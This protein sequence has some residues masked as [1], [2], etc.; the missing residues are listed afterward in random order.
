V[1]PVEAV[2]LKD[3]REY[4]LPLAVIEYPEIAPLELLL[5]VALA[6]YT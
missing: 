1:V 6:T 5:T 3:E 2:M 4:E